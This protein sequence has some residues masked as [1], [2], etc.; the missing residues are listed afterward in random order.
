VVWSDE[1]GGEGLWSTELENYQIP[2]SFKNKKALPWIKALVG[3]NSRWR[4]HELITNDG[5]VHSRNL[6]GSPALV[7]QQGQLTRDAIVELKIGGDDETDLVWFNTKSTDY[8]GHFYGYESDECGEV[9]SAADDESRQIVELIE[10]RTNGD[11]VVVLTADHGAAR[12][13]EVS[14]AYRIDR[15][16]LKQELNETFDR[17]ANNIDVVQVIT[18]GQIYLNHGELKANG[19]K[20]SDVV[21]FL[22]KYKANMVF[23]YN[24]LADEWIKKRKAR[25]ALFFEDVVAKETLLGKK[26]TN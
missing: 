8:C 19:F 14:G 10:K 23:P 11:F 20:V 1:N 5:R 18:V 24:A 22:K 21:R 4:G 9:L 2:E 3:K 15:L 7:R 26:G 17:L 25:E 13:P 6:L 16:K 12:L